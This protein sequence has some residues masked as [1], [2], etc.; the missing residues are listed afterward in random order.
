MQCEDE[1][2]IEEIRPQMNVKWIPQVRQDAMQSRRDRNC[3]RG[4]LSVVFTKKRR[5]AKS[6]EIG[7]RGQKTH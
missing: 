7:Y 4:I 1:K 5:K 3:H 2:P 6:V